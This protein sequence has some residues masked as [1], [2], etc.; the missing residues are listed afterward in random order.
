MAD[1]L[2]QAKSMNPLGT[3]SLP[4]NNT[5]SSAASH[6]E[7][8]DIQK[9]EGK[10]KTEGKQKPAETGSKDDS[11]T[12]PKESTGR[13]LEDNKELLKKVDNILKFVYPSSG[14]TLEQLLTASLGYL[15]SGRIEEE[16]LDNV[17]QSD[18]PLGDD[19]YTGYDSDADTL[20]IP[21]NE[22]TEYALNRIM[23]AFMSENGVII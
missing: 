3:Q 11:K 10:H 21:K 19:P 17:D 13:F 18:R 14:I 12:Y 23:K 5:G 22:F 7:V 1:N 4:Q 20:V 8:Q 2:I 15:S 9:P 16:D 6:E